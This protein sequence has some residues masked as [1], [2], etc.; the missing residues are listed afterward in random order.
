[1]FAVAAGLACLAGAALAAPEGGPGE[2]VAIGSAQQ[3]ARGEPFP[4][5]HESVRIPWGRLV[6]GTAAVSGL[7]CLGV[8]MLKKL[9][10]GGAFGRGRY[11]E[12]LEARPV[13]RDVQLFLVRVAGRVVLLASGRSTVSRL[14]EFREDELP[15]RDLAGPEG[16][17]GF[18][19]LLQ[20]VMGAHT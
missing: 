18:R 15:E 12:L 10:R 9:N 11:L 1:M 13:G 3:S 5:D 20:K 2:Q 14:A 4:W 8:W 16:L 7:I 17:E 19:A 6:A